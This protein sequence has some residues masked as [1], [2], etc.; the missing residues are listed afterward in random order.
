MKIVEIIVPCFNEEGCI[1]PF[2]NAINDVFKTDKLLNGYGF[3]ITFIDDGSTDQTVE[4]INRMMKNIEFG[5][6]IRYLSF[7]RNFGKEAAIYAGME[8]STGDFVVLM[9][10]DLQHPPTLLPKMMQAIATEGYDCATARRVLRKNESAVRRKGSEYFYRIFRH[11]TG[12]DLLPGSTDFRL[13]RRSVVDAILKL[14]ERERFTKGIYSWI[15]FKNKWIEYE[16]VERQNGHTK[17]S[18]RGLI[19]YAYNGFVAFATTPLRAVAYL[20]M[21]VVVAA[22]VSAIIVAIITSSNGTNA[23]GTTLI[24]IAMLLLNGMIITILGVIGEYLARIYMEV[25]GRPIYIVRDAKGSC[26]SVDAMDANDE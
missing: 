15:G 14:P 25:K 11:I 5:E 24:M 9:D 23:N 19:G 21:L 22:I 1:S 26:T 20:G 16:N 17:W 18:T 7:S 12:L 3:Q 4:E 8:Y 13:M 10:A 2:C 6:K